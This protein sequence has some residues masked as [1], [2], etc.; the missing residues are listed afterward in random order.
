V[1]SHGELVRELYTERLETLA[2][3]RGWE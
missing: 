3:K 2:D 1:N